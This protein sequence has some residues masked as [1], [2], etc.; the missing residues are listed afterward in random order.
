MKIILFVTTITLFSIQAFANS[1][2]QEKRL[3]EQY[4]KTVKVDKI[5]RLGNPNTVRLSMDG[6]ESEFSYKWDDKT[7]KIL[8]KYEGK[9]LDKSFIDY[10]ESLGCILN[11]FNEKV[12]IQCDSKYHPLKD[13]GAE[14]LERL[15]FSERNYTKCTN[16]EID[17]WKRRIKVLTTEIENHKSF[18]ADS[19]I[20]SNWVKSQM[21]ANKLRYNISK[22]VNGGGTESVFSNMSEKESGYKS[23]LIDLENIYYSLIHE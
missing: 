19:G 4:K 8:S 17:L 6:K 13:H 9:K 22:I 15:G 5:L 21:D 16:A 3:W 23:I 1:K 18:K 20:I 11:I 2:K 12:S 14:C 7:W 10:D